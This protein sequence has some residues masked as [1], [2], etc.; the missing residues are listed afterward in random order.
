[1]VILVPED[2]LI[3]E[4]YFCYYSTG[5]KICNP[6]PL[7]PEKESNMLTVPEIDNLANLWNSWDC[8]TEVVRSS[9]LLGT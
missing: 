4:L 7:N 2:S 1:M 5:R 9:A 3:N 6:L 8:L